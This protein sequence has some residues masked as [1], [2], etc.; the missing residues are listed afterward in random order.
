M[1]KYIFLATFT[2]EE[3]GKYSVRYHDLPGCYTFG[4]DIEDGMKNSKEALEL[5]LYG[6]E[7]DGDIIPEPSKATQIPVENNEFLIPIQVY[8]PIVRLEMDNKNDKKTLTIPHWLNK[9]AEG[10]NINFSA[11]LQQAIKDTLGIKEYNR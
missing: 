11:L 3:D 9:L 6:M 2:E 5:H 4:D 8:M 7:E 10:E 1:D